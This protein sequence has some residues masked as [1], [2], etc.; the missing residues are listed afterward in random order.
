MASKRKSN[1]LNDRQQNFIREYL[2][3]KGANLNGTQ[4]AIRAG[5]SRRTAN[6][7]AS[8]LLA[9]DSIADEIEKRRA[10]RM[11]KAELTAEM[12]IRE[13]RLLG[14]SNMRDYLRINDDGEPEIDLSLAADDRDLSAPIQEVTVETVTEGRNE[15]KR[16][17][18]RTKFKLSDKRSSLEL[19]G[20]H[21]GIFDQDNTE[22]R[23]RLDELNKAVRAP[24]SRPA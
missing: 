23:D 6:E 7:Q 11:E 20:K 3:P 16:Y 18:R 21:L 4:A 22:K 24:L 2:D 13:L 10:R 15:E 1:K 9:N 14:F 12:V 19:L 17:V 8:R 5:Y